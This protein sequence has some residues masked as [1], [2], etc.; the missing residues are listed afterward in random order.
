MP[1]QAMM[2]ETSPRFAVASP[3]AQGSM[4]GRQ[5]GAGTCGRIT[6]CSWLMRISP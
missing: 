6:F 5:I 4:D 2:S 1:G 3:P